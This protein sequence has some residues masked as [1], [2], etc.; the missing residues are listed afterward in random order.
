MLALRGEPHPTGLPT[1]DW[2]W[3]ERWG[4]RITVDGDCRSVACAKPLAYVREF[5]FYRHH[6]GP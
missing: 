3:G 2:W 6:F 1:R 5:R 4:E